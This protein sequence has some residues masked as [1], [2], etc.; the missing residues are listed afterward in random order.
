MIWCVCNLLSK[1]IN[2][3]FFFIC[4]LYLMKIDHKKKKSYENRCLIIF[5]HLEGW[6]RS[7]A[8]F[9]TFTGC[10][11]C[12]FFSAKNTREMDTWNILPKHLACFLW[13]YIYIYIIIIIISLIEPIRKIVI[14]YEIIIFKSFS[15]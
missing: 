15:F 7:V 1:M 11:Q 13:L 2:I 14:V 8:G 3:S 5:W 9:P 4:E 12:R 10:L 6:V